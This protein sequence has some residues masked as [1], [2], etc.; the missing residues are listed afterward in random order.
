MVKR[1]MFLF[2]LGSNG[3]SLIGTS[4]LDLW[5]LYIWTDIISRVSHPKSDPVELLVIYDTRQHP[6]HQCCITATV[7]LQVH[8]DNNNPIKKGF[9]I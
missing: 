4:I 5:S 1:F 6:G 9:R 8:R 2:G 7:R 3:F